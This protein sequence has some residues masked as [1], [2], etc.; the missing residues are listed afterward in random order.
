MAEAVAAAKEGVAILPET[1]APVVRT[2]ALL[3]LARF[4]D[5][6]EETAGAESALDEAAALCAVK[7][8]RVL[9]DRT[10]A[11][12]AEILPSTAARAV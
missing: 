5:R 10:E 8:M 11:L 12:R 4:C 6:A 9:A 1:E 7:Q 2:E 3:E